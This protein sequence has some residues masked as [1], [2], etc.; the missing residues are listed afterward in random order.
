MKKFLVLMSLAILFC[1]SCTDTVEEGKLAE[2]TVYAVSND[3]V[4]LLY[5]HNA[6]KPVTL[7]KPVT[8]DTLT[9]LGLP[10]SVI[11]ASNKN[12]GGMKRYVDGK[13]NSV[14]DISAGTMVFCLVGGIMIAF[15]LLVLLFRD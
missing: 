12:I 15:V 8:L 4:V 3:S 10:T 14:Y 6:I 5:Y 13:E 1:V 2:K 11:E 9:K 7:K